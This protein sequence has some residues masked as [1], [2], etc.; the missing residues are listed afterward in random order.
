MHKKTLF[1]YNRSAA[2]ETLKNRTELEQMGIFDRLTRMMGAG[3]DKVSREER[4]RE[5]LLA[6]V[7]EMTD[8]RLAGLSDYGEK[9]FPAIEFA[10]LYYEE[11][12]STLPD[13]I[14]LDGSHKLL[15]E[16][17]PQP[18]DRC[19]CLGR[20][21][22]VKHE[23]PH[24]R[25]RH[26]SRVYALLGMR[27]KEVSGGGKQFVDHTLRSLR[28][29]PN[30]VRRALMDAAFDSLLQNFANQNLHYEKKLEQALLYEKMLQEARLPSQQKEAVSPPE[31]ERAPSVRAL[32]PIFRDAPEKV[33]DNLVECLYNPSE[34]LQLEREE[35]YLLSVP[36]EESHV[37]P[38]MKTQDRRQWY[39]CIVGF[40]VKMA[41]AALAKEAHNHRFILI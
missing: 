32:P 34:R 14:T 3:D 31:T 12:L 17:F 41:E 5:Q 13:N 24:H 25:E 40:P 2:L 37:L 33:L 18:E 22:A 11:I 39:V 9:L 8:R 26:R 35:G 16:I 23:L 15:V 19:I 10:R 1:T 7:V 36:D 30:A 6:H 27:Q 4:A 38:L 21:L 29:S 28:H 20:S